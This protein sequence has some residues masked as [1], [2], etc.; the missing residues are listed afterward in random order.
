MDGEDSKLAHGTLGNPQIG[1]EEEDMFTAAS[2]AAEDAEPVSVDFLMP[3]HQLGK[4]FNEHGRGMGYSSKRE[5]DDAAKEF[6]ASN[7]N[8][9]AATVR[10]GVW[11]G[12]G[13]RRGDRQRAISN[14]G[15]TVIIDCSTGQIIDFYD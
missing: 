12:S 7:Q 9:D 2:N 13:S 4:H 11:N 14:E 3:M 6:A 1:S 8:N 10:E 5:Y 15:K